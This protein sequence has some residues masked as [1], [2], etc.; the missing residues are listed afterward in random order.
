MSRLNRT[1]SRMVAHQVM[2][3]KEG[4]PLAG[5]GC[6]PSDATPTP[7]IPHGGLYG[8]CEMGSTGGTYP[9]IYGETVYSRDGYGTHWDPCGNE[10]QAF[11]VVKQ[12][13]R[14][15]DLSI[16]G[17]R[18]TATFGGTISATSTSVGRAIC[19]AALKVVESK[20]KKKPRR[21]GTRR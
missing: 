8:G 9:F 16:R 20:R 1:I 21:K 19:F 14:P 15:F 13:G 6:R 4:E 17:P 12:V 10:E 2:G 5:G 11:M 7:K 3:W 18:V